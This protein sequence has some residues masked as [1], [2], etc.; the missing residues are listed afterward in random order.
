[1]VTSAYWSPYLHARPFDA[2]SSQLIACFKA[3]FIQITNYATAAALEETLHCNSTSAGQLP[4][5][6]ARFPEVAETRE[7]LGEGS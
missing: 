7:D 3:S 1:M 6:Q 2:L 4:D 5:I